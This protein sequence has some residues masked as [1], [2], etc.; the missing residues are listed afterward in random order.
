LPFVITMPQRRRGR[1]RLVWRF[2]AIC[3]AGWGRAARSSGHR[4]AGLHQPV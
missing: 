4:A 3:T 2:V 1:L